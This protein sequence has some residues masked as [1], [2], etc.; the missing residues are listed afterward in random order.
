MLNS[1][2]KIVICM[3]KKINIPTLVF[4]EKKFQNDKKKHNPPCKLNGRSLMWTLKFSGG[5]ILYGCHLLSRLNKY[6]IS[7]DCMMNSLSSYTIRNRPFHDNCGTT[8]FVHSSGTFVSGKKWQFRG[9]I[10]TSNTFN[11]YYY[12]SQMS[13][14][15]A[16]P[17]LCYRERAIAAKL[18]R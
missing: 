18:C 2:K 11:W 15:N 16:G 5:D 17:Q 13:R 1:G 3:T 9:K 10:M 14:M 12:H 4:S 8:F 6:F 7:S